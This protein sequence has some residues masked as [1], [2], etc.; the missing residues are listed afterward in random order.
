MKLAIIFYELNNW[1]IKESFIAFV[2]VLQLHLFIATWVTKL[3]DWSSLSAG[4]SSFGL[5]MFLFILLLIL[6]F[7]LIFFFDLNLSIFCLLF[8]FHLS[9]FFLAL[10]LVRS[11]LRFTLFLLWH[12]SFKHLCIY[13]THIFPVAL[14]LVQLPWF[15]TD[16]RF[17]PQVSIILICINFGFKLI[18][19]L[20]WNCL[21]H[22]L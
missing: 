17:L 4:I 13:F 10:L 3:S 9:I 18:K 20:F 5:R 7:I 12:H 1:I 8:N 15:R 21:L 14:F 2:V 22:D 11:F 19:F 6:V 16:N